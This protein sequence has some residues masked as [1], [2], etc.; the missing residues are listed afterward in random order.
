VLFRGGTVLTMDGRRPHADVVVVERGR[1][2]TVGDRELLERTDATVVDLDGGTLVP[3]FI[4]AHSH[5]SI[6]ALH[7]R[8][9]DASAVSDRDTLVAAVVAH[10]A[11]EPTAAWVRL[12][13]WED[14]R[15]GYVPTRADL[16]AA[17]VDRPVL[18]AHS[19]L[20]QCVTSSAGL[21]ILGIGRDTPDPPGGEIGRDASGHPNGLL[22]ERAWGEAHARSLAA[23]ADPDRWAEHLADHLHG[24]L[25]DG[26]TAVHDAACAPS[27]EAVYR[28]MATADTLPVSVLAMPHPAVLLRAE[29]GDRLD[30]PPTG[31]GDERFRVGPIKLFADGGVAIALDVAIGGRPLRM[32]STMEGLEEAAVAAASRDFRLAVH[33]MGNVGVDRALAAFEAVGR[34]IG[35]GDHRFRI[36]HAAVTAPAQ[37]SRLAALGGIAVVQ[38]G[39]VEHIGERSGGIGFDEH[40]W[41]AFAGLADAGV[42]LAGS[43]D[44]PCAPRSPLW[45][46]RKGISRTTSARICLEADQS[47][48]LDAWLHAYTA[49][50]ALAGG[51]EHERGRIAPGLV[52]DLVVLDAEGDGEG[53]GP[54]VRQTW[55]AGK[56]VYQAVPMPGGNRR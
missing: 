42:V 37:W 5:P 1:I 35:D 28:T 36:E 6:A 41:L 45:C 50:A 7:P 49:G 34:R 52:A 25:A 38:P 30:G 48:G 21:D 46:A 29:P 11:S 20:H 10:A 40:R 3:A 47:V 53:S 18:V 27:A 39:F 9:G 13:G 32:G 14:A 43:S 22:V 54:T 17:G 26:I 8:W 33:A 55:R 31:E 15:T 51:Q 24:L 44:E 23:Y 16:D 19:S 12:H 2:A 56:L 4:D